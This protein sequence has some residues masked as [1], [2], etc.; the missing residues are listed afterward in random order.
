VTVPGGAFDEN[1]FSTMKIRIVR[2]RGF[3]RDDRMGSR[4]VA[5]VNEEFARTYWPNQDPVGK[6][7]RLDRPDG[8]DAEVVGIAKTGRYVYPTEPP[9]PYVYLP[10]EQ[11]QR[12]RMT[13]IAESQG[14]PAALAAP[15]REVVRPTSDVRTKATTSAACFSVT[16][17]RLHFPLPLEDD[18]L[19]L[20]VGLGLHFLGAPAA[21]G[22][23]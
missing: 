23:R 17:D 20:G 11:N 9:T 3:S 6:R 13:L 22:S 7:L 15:L 16:P 5:V 1:Y 12:A 21:P 14:N 19:Q 2:G 8:P 10:Y 4:R 18:R